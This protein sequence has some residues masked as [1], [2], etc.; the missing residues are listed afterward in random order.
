MNMKRFSYPAGAAAT[1]MGAALTW[2]AE[3]PA[4]P[5]GIADLVSPSPARPIPGAPM[6]P[7]APSARASITLPAHPVVK[8]A[9]FTWTV[10]RPIP[11]ALQTATKARRTATT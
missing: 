5:T 3:R 9:A 4:T 2:T 7:E 11:E 8:G 6:I 10:E 1:A